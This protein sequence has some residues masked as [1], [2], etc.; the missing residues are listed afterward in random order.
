[1]NLSSKSWPIAI[2]VAFLGM[3]SLR[4][5]DGQFTREYSRLYTALV[6]SFGGILLLLVAIGVWQ[7]WRR[8]VQGTY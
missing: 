6:F 1:M 4:V 2:L 7:A 5:E 8:R 3:L